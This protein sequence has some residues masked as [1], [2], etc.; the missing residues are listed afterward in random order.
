MLMQGQR[1]S[2][3][4]GGAV[5]SKDVGQLQGWLRQGLRPAFPLGGPPAIAA[6]VVERTDCGHELWAHLDV[7]HCGLDAAMTEQ[8]L[9]DAAI[10]A[11]LQKMGAKTVAQSIL[12]L[13]MICTQPRFAIGI[14]RSMA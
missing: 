3:S 5:L 4:V 2:L 9:N 11:V 12:I 8:D 13:L 6:E 1:V 7:T 14:I 10:G